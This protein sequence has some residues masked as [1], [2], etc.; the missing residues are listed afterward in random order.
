M[1]PAAKM[2]VLQKN[3]LKNS[4]KKMLDK[5]RKE[6]RKGIMNTK[7]RGGVGR[8][9]AG[10]GTGIFLQAVQYIEAYNHSVIPELVN[11]S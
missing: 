11:I 10:A 7:V 4:K 3:H 1:G 8:G 6:V 2:G 5:G 9:A